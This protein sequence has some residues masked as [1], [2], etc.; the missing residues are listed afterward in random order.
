MAGN[1]NEE[2]GSY[3]SGFSRI[4]SKHNLV[5][6]IQQTHGIDGKPP[7]Y[8]RGRRRLDYIFVTTG[9]SMSVIHCGIL[10]YS[11]ILNLDHRCLYA[12][13]DTAMLL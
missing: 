13:F 2:L 12:G 11:D 7:T 5:E 1:L 10:P 3:L 4:S 8:A 6:I 9:L